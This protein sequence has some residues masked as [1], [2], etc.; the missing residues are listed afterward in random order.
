MFGSVTVAVTASGTCSFAVCSEIDGNCGPTFISRTM[1]VKIFVVVK[2]GFTR[3][4]TSLLVITT[5]T[6]FELGDCVCCGVQVNTPF[7]VMF[8]PD[9]GLIRPYPSVLAWML[10][11]TTG[12]DAI[13]E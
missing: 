6:V 7:D 9:S 13:D 2:F 5:V 3:S 1:T 12:F 10:V 8:I 4:N 11:C